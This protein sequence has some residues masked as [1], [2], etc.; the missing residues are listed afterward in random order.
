M[1]GTTRKQLVN[2]VLRRLRE[3]QLTTNQAISSNTYATMIGDF[4]NDIKEEVEDAWNWGQLRAL[5]TIT[6]ASGTSVYDVDASGNTSN[7]RSQVLSMWNTTQDY[8]IRLQSDAFFNRLTLVGTQQNNTPSW[9]RPKGCNAT[10]DKQVEL[11]PV[12]NGIDTI[13]VWLYNPQDD[14]SADTDTLSLSSAQKA[15]VYGTWAMAISERGEDGGQ[16]YDEVTAKY[17][18]YLDTAISMDR[19]SYEDEADW[20]VV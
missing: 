8:E 11:Y 16:L 10:G 14:L 19:A 15:I 6:T 13:K 4:L 1:A 9:Y 5:T 7:E 17:K 2:E 12:P 20:V 18:F 3:D